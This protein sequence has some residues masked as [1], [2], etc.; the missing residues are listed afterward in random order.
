[1]STQCPSQLKSYV[2]VRDDKLK[3]INNYHLNVLLNKYS[4]FNDSTNEN[5]KLMK[6]KYDEQFDKLNQEMIQ[7]LHDDTQRLLE[8]HKEFI[9]KNQQVEKNRQLL[10]KLKMEIKDAE[11]SK[12]S[13]LENNADIQHY[14]EKYSFWHSITFYINI[15]LFLGIILSVIYFMYYG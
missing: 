7:L 5:D 13:R 3:K 10:R 11:V 1:M 6:A 15:V 8:Q 4:N 9:N 14:Q 12:E 2:Q